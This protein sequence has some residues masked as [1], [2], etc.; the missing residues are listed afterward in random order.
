MNED[1]KVAIA[2]R[3][4][5]EQIS[6][7]L[8]EPI[9]RHVERILIARPARFIRHMI[10]LSPHLSKEG[11]EQLIMHDDAEGRA[12]VAGRNDLSDEQTERLALDQNE[13]TLLSLATKKNISDGTAR[14]LFEN[15]NATVRTW[16]V[17]RENAPDDVL[18]RALD[19]PAISVRRSLAGR[20]TLS[21]ERRLILLLDDDTQVRL[22]AIGEASVTGLR[23]A[24]GDEYAE[25]RKEAE[26]RLD[27][28][29]FSA[30][31]RLL[32]FDDAVEALRS[33][34]EKRLRKA[35]RRIELLSK[36]RSGASPLR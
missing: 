36:L 10:A 15:G 16:M 5:P 14:R 17:R 28:E 23:V 26:K 6:L 12:F 2:A 33:L 27:G 20:K 24:L 35:N 1:S 22:G 19:D 32:A 7:M 13:T 3:G 29:F 11:I 31:E 30:H 4:T 18:E 25:I 8:K 34:P 21:D 9:S